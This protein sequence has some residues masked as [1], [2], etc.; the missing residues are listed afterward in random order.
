MRL[1]LAK[2]L[3]WTTL[4]CISYSLAVAYTTLCS[5]TR[6]L[7][8]TFYVVI[9]ETLHMLALFELRIQSEL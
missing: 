1:K 3:S 6:R 2:L 9:R 7:A 4:N 5:A 8:R